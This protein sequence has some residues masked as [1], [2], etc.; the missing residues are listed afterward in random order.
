MGV[1]EGEGGGGW[2]SKALTK[3]LRGTQL[4]ATPPMDWCLGMCQACLAAGS[5]PT[6]QILARSHAQ[7]GGCPLDA[8][9]HGDQLSHLHFLPIPLAL[10]REGDGTSIRASEQK[11]A[12]SILGPAH[13]LPRDPPT[14]R[15]LALC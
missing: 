13:Q 3:G 15:T 8:R 5:L 4:W 7:E 14:P 12:T 9:L 6:T 1:A 11:Q 2:G 10:L